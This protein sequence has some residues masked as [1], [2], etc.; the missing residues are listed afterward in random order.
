M[1]SRDR[2]KRKKKK[3]KGAQR[4]KP[5]P[6]CMDPALELDYKNVEVLKRFVSERGKIV[7]R[8]N[9]GVCAKHQR[10]LAKEI[11]RARF[12]GLLPYIVYT[13]R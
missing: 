9:S 10:R 12:L 1:A 13:Y 5:C 8:R 7:A 11:K 6:F 2:R 4:Q 3:K